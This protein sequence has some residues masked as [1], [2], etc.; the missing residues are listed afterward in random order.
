MN[1]NNISLEQMNKL[2]KEIL[3]KQSAVTLEEAKA[4]VLRLKQQSS[5]KYKKQ[6]S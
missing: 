4:Q 3:S 5:Q 6:K 1:Y 2:G